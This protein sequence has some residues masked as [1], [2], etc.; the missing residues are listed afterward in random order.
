MSRALEAE[1]DALGD[2]GTISDVRDDHRAFVTNTRDQVTQWTALSEAIAA[3][4]ATGIDAARTEI[5][6]LSRGRIELADELGI[7]GCRERT[8]G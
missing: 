6:E 7:G 8:F 2:V 1:A 4:D 3:A 5:L